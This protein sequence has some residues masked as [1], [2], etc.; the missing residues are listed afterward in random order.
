MEKSWF[1]ANTHQIAVTKPHKALRLETRT[2][3]HGKIVKL[4][5]AGG[6][7]R[8]VEICGPCNKGKAAMSSRLARRI[9][10]TSRM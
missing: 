7:A 10:S 5:V 3:R 9:R 8:E 6:T 4:R 1:K 2:K